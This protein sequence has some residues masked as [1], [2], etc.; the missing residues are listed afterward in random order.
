MRRSDYETEHGKLTKY[1][2]LK[3]YKKDYMSRE[4]KEK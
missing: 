1:L 2:T 4:A 3:K